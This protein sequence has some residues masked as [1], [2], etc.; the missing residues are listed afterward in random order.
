MSDFTTLLAGV[1][2]PDKTTRTEAETHL[3]ELL[4][5][6]PVA[7]AQ[8]FIS[9][10]TSTDDAISSLSAVLFRKKILDTNHFASFDATTK[11]ALTGSLV[12]LV[13]SARTLSFLK[14]IG[15]IL[16]N[17]ASTG[18]WAGDF[19]KLCVAWGG[20]SDLKE[21]SLY[22]LEIA[23]EFPKLLALMEISS[24]EVVQ[25]LTTFFADSNRETVLS[26]VNTLASLLSGLKEENKVMTYEPLAKTMIEVL[27]STTTGGKLKLALTSIADLTEVYPRFWKDVVGM[28]T[29]ALT[30]IATAQ[31][32]PDT[33]SSAVEVLVTL[34]QRAPGMVKKD[35]TVVVE[36]CQ[37]AMNLTYEIDLKDELDEW[38]K[39][40]TDLSVTNNDPYSLGKDLLSKS[41]K[42]LE[43]PQVLP[44]YLQ[45]IPMFLKDQDWVKQHTAL[46]TVGFIAEGCHDRFSENINELLAM[47]MPFASSTNPRLQWAFS[48]T[49]G[50][51]CS[52]FEPK[53]QAEYHGIIVPALL[54]IMAT[55]TNVKAQTQAVSAL[56]NFTRGVLTDDDTETTPVSTYAANTLKILAGL[57][58]KTSSYKLMNETLGA[59]S[60]TATAMEDEFAPYYNEFMPALKSMVTMTFTTPEQHE[61]RANCIRCMGH[62]VES[63]SEN[64]GAYIND[65]KGVM[66]GLITLKGTLDSDDPTTLAINEVVSQFSDCLKN[67]FIPYMEV[68]MPDL[69]A[70]ATA[71]VDMAF[72]DAGIELPSGMNS[73]NLNLKGQG[74]KQIAV[75]TTVLQHKIKACRILFDLVSSLK[76][77]FAPWAIATLNALTPLFNYLYNGDIR[78][79][80]MKTVVAVFLTLSGDSA[81]TLLR[82]LTPV[83]V[84]TLSSPKSSPSDIKRALK[85][86]QACLEHTENKAVIGLA[87][88]NEIA[89][90]TST[91][92]RYVFDRKAQRKEEVK[93][94]SDPDLY[95]DE[96]EAIKEENE[97]DEKILSGVMEVVGMLLKGFK[98]EFQ[99]TFL[100]Y[101]KTLY[102]EVFFKEGATDGE[103][104][105]AICIFDDYVENTQDLM[106]AGNSSPIL[107]QMLKFST[108]K[109]ADIRQSAVFGIGVCAQSVDSTTFSPFLAQA[110]SNIKTVL[111]DPKARNDT[112]TIATDCAVG[113]LGKIALYHN[114]GLLEEWVNFLPIKA[115]L[116]E[117][118]C[119]HLMFLQNIDKVKTF[120]RTQTVL[121]E[122]VNLTK[123]EEVLDANGMTLLQQLIN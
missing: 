74:D 53:I 51:L 14:K 44:F 90:A 78:K 35:N 110:L 122:L 109:N 7:V 46:L 5:A 54:N 60:V 75:N 79:Y 88:A 21:L 47:I 62:C 120:P 3:T 59:I 2:N 112:Y 37:A 114:A 25:L 93:G 6:S 102:G 57:L 26:A 56:V 32:D 49:L 92:V 115:E 15:D 33:R 101:F 50:L 111:T 4:T 105:S 29:K 82:T 52:E 104:L 27:V 8:Q 61:V 77:S 65:V 24:D 48:T 85:S 13:T 43:A 63:I 107:E 10:M 95:A 80:S 100:Q 121:A 91:H 19:F 22:L 94:F 42:F 31:I 11:N 106:W 99:G 116:D 40:E 123:T 30:T 28:F 98:K 69:L 16:A 97:V 81:E 34:V 103:I 9:A 83:F 45:T 1:L 39:D 108:H 38:T 113:A 72:I 119:V 70:K 23:V 66:N 117:A 76:D 18:E 73:V 64:P 58:Q 96:I 84:Q 55:A 86:L 20:M 118:Q 87:A 36:I 68:F 71:E 67:E 41:A 12:S 89:V 17:I